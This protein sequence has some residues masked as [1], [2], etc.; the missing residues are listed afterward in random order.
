MRRVTWARAFPAA[1]VLE[2]P[3]MALA[4]GSRL[5]PYEIL[6]AIG[7]GGMGEV[8]KARDSRLG[9]TVAVKILPAEFTSDP[10]RRARFEREA[11]AVAALSHPNVVSIFDVDIGSEPPYAVIELLEGETLREALGSGPL[12]ARKAV[13]YG[14]QIALGLA[15]AHEKGIVHRDL[16]PEN[17]FVT[18]EGRAKVLDFGLAK[19]PEPEPGAALS[20]M[21]T[22]QQVTRA[23]AVFGTVAYM[24]PEQARGEPVDARSDIF[25]LGAILYEMLCGRLAF[26]GPSVAE[27]MAAIL[28]RDVPTLAASGTDAPPLLQRVVTRCLEKR[29]EERLQ[30]AL[31][32]A[33]ALES[34]FEVS[35]AAIGGKTAASP[36]RWRTALGLAALVGLAVGAALQS[37]RHLSV[38]SRP[39]VLRLSLPLPEDTTLE[40]YASASLAVSPSGGTIAFIAKRGGTPRLYVRELDAASARELPGTEGAS[41]PFFSPDGRWLGF[42]S[43]ARVRKVPVAGGTPQTI[44]AAPFFSGGAWGPGDVIVFEQTFTSGLWRVS[45][46]GGLPQR[47]TTLDKQRGEGGHVWPD[48]GPGGR[49]VLFTIWT[50]GSFDEAK[51]ALLSLETGRYA[52]LLENAYF[53]RFA[54][55]E[56][57][58]FV[59]GGRAFAI[60]YDPKTRQV[61]G[62]PTLVQE[63]VRSETA[64][65]FALLAAS[66][67]VLLYA[68]GSAQP[69]RRSLVWVDREGRESPAAGVVRG[70]TAARLS[71]T[72]DRIATSVESDILSLWMWSPRREALT[73]FSFSPDDHSVAWSPDGTSVAFESGRN[74]THEV[75][76][77]AVDGSGHDRQVTRGDRES[78]ISDW[79]PDGGLLAFTRFDHETGA[80]LY[81]VDPRGSGAPR[82]FATTPFFESKAAFSPD[83]RDLAYVSDESGRD[84]VYVRP[85][86][87]EGKVQVSVDGGTEPAW[88]R[89]GDEVYYRG[90]DNVMAA[91]VGRSLDV[92]TPVALFPDRYF[93]C[94][95][96]SR[97]YDVGKD[98]RFLMIRPVEESPVKE[99][100][101]VVGW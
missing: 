75:F 78:Y 60:G 31:D 28:S 40:D 90:G 88:S 95:E 20:E 96:Q 33:F 1:R 38:P 57:I 99:L 53:G 13:D 84:E 29:R 100:Q 59:R 63:G 46:Q 32:V 85:L 27:T 16:K 62:E 17:V 50:G 97:T 39:R 83:G 10:A 56:R 21:T 69:P 73:R 68:T 45:A 24:S 54:G 77:G 14:R 86:E 71:P 3:R 89:S 64:D 25:A 4:A 70:F 11:R 93:F 92:H 36:W 82:P 8:Y 61:V 6:A 9:R 34:V 7:K 74:G 81:L 18:V 26:P 65:G 22:A 67:S 5:G 44:T 52:V 23:G 55:P 30:S 72:D 79:A 87:G 12:P 51:L 41:N 101:V 37:A 66:P 42:E 35:P 94:K 43:R 58:L 91:R 76:V 98:G 19:E 15:A 48:F 49:D 2:V 47:L 80:D